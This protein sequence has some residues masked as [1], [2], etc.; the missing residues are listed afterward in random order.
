MRRLLVVSLLAVLSTACASVNKASPAADAEAK[1]FL[2]PPGKSNV[3][4]FRDESFGGA[5]GL[6]VLLDGKN[7]GTTG[8][9]TYVLATVAPGGHQ[10]LSKA[11][12]DSILEVTAEA[13][14]NVYVWQE[15]K[16]GVWKARSQL[17]LIDEPAAKARIGACEL[18]LP[19]AP[20]TAAPATAAPAAVPAS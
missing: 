6:D 3:Y 1:K 12:N 7:I 15:V 9:K 14:K 13:G 8:A 20:A 16:M 19:L 4:V 17:Q 2:A 5:V 11:E 18:V 10:L